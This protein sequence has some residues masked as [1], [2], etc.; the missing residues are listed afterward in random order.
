MVV[1]QVCEA[2]KKVS[3][4]Q[5][6][7]RP[8]SCSFSPCSDASAFVS[9]RSQKNF[10]QMSSR[11]YFGGIGG[12]SRINRKARDQLKF[13]GP[14]AARRTEAIQVKTSFSAFLAGMPM[15]KSFKQAIWSH[16]LTTYMSCRSCLLRCMQY[17]TRP[18]PRASWKGGRAGCSNN[19]RMLIAWHSMSKELT[20]QDCIWCILTRLLSRPMLILPDKQI[21]SIPSGK[22]AIF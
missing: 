6:K 14:A 12:A 10:L 21:S 3:Q 17:A 7:L 2:T 5:F 9:E 13:D 8:C 20:V 11:V 15:A 22:G 19:S 1:L 18:M 16:S 4:S